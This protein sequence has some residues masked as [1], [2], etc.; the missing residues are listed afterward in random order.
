MLEEIERHSNKTDMLLI[1]EDQTCYK[2]ATCFM[3]T[4]VSVSLCRLF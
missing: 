4:V 1:Q 3:F 2:K